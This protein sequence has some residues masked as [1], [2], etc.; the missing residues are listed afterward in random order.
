MLFLRN[1]F[2]AE[3]DKG[4][5]SIAAFNTVM[6]TSAH[7]TGQEVKKNEARAQRG[8]LSIL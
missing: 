3:Q 4:G 2:S 5:I 1:M 6:Q 7:P 8:Y